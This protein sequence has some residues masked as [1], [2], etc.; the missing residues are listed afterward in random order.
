LPWS[1]SVKA[2]AERKKAQEEAVAKAT[3][4]RAA[5][6]A[7]DPKFASFE[8]HTKGIG[9]RLLEKM[10]FKAGEGLGRNRQGIAKPLEP[11]L[12]PKGMGMGFGD[13]KEAKM[14]LPGTKEEEEEGDE[15]KG[16]KE[17]AT[18]AAVMVSG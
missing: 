1:C 13:F 14:V 5:F 10:G 8:T 2:A 18:A 12:R 9:T 11:K 15:G 3:N 4:K 6:K 7:A 16:E 17:A